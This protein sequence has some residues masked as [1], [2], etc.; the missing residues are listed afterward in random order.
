MTVSL[1][2]LSEVDSFLPLSGLQHVVYCERQAALIHVDKIWQENTA[3]ALGRI[4][5]ERVDVPGRDHRRGVRVVRSMPLFSA[6]LRLSGIADTVEYHRIDRKG[7]AEQPFPV[8]YKRGRVRSLLADQ[9]QLCAQAICL[10]ELHGMSVPQGA[11]FY[12]A[13]HRRVA[14][15][16]DDTLRKQTRAAAARLHSF[17]EQRRVPPAE[18]GPR[19]AGCSLEPMCMPELTSQRDRVKRYLSTLYE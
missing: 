1:G 2:G 5:H 7:S 16:F 15:T 4:V 19:C 10:E 14:V 3:T 18:P 11:L 13:S 8:E 12:D 17:V 6:T 9:V